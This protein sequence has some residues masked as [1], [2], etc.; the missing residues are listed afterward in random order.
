M[1]GQPMPE[2]IKDFIN[3]RSYVS[4]E[5]GEAINDFIKDFDPIPNLSIYHDDVNPKEV[6]SHKADCNSQH[7]GLA[8]KKLFAD[9]FE[10]IPDVTIYHD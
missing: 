1:K 3:E 2:A 7:D 9:E 6:K 10:P 4:Q 5:K 8:S